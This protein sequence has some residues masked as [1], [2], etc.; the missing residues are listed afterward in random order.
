MT[1][2]LESV[3]F[4][5]NDEDRQPL[6]EQFD[7]LYRNACASSGILRRIKLRRLICQK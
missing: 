5:G 3:A 4:G 1:D 6:A 2:M 7:K